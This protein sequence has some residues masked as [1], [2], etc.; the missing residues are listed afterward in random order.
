MRTLRYL[1]LLPL[2]LGCSPDEIDPD[3]ITGVWTGGGTEY[4]F[5]TNGDYQLRYPYPGY[6]QSALPVDSIWGVYVV[7]EVRH[8]VELRPLGYRRP[9]GTVV[10]EA[11]P[12]QV[13]NVSFP[14]SNTLRYESRTQI[15]FLTRR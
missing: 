5:Q 1:L 4:T 7:D 3:L 15:G 14:E 11:L 2:L 9:D 13:W 10:V 8:N 6:D 12:R